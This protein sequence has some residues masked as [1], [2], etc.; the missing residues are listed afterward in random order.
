MTRPNSLPE[1]RPDHTPKPIARAKRKHHSRRS[2]LRVEQLEDRTTPSLLSTFELDGNA[3][4]TTSH[5]WDQVFA[6][7]GSPS[8][9]GST[10][11]ANGPLSGAL[12][13]G[14]TKDVTNSNTDDIFTGG[15][16]KDTNG[17]HNWLFT[18]SR[19][20]GKDDIEN[21]FAAAYTDPG[22]GHL[23]LYAGL[24]RFDNSGDSTA[25]F[26]FFGNQIGQ[27]PNVT[28]NGGHPFVGQHRN[29][30]I[31]L[32]SNFTQGGSVS[33]IAVYEWVGNDSTGGL[34]F[35]GG[36]STNTFAVVNSA[37]VSVPWSYTNKA[38]QSQPQAGEFLEE[39]VDLTALGLSGCFDSFTAE[40]RSSQ[41]PTATLSDFTL[42]R[43]PVCTIAAT[44]F[45][46]LSKFDTYTHQGDVVTY[47]L[48]VTNTG[49]VTLYLQNVTDTV[50]GNIAVNGVVQQP[51]AAGVN[52]FVTSITTSGVT[53]NGA[54]APGASATFFVSRPVQQTDPDPTTD[55]VTFVYNDDPGPTFGPD[56]DTASATN[57][58]NL[59]QPSVSLAETASAPAGVAGTP[60]TYTYTLTNT[61]SADSPNLVLD[62]SSPG[63]SFNS[64]LFGN[65]EA[66]AVH[67]LA[68][69][70][71][72]TTA[73]LAPGAS[74]SFTE[75]HVLSA[76]DPTPLTD[77]TGAVCTLAQNLGAFPNLI[78][79]NLTTVTVRIVNAEIGITGSGVNEVNNPHTFTVTVKEDLGDGNGFVPAANEP[80][81]VTLTSSPG[82]NP[83]VETP[84]SGTTDASGQFQVTFTSATAGEVI[85]S[86]TTTFTIQGVNL[87]RATSDS[88]VGDSGPATKFFEDA[89]ITISPSATN[90]ITEPHTFTVTL[91]DNAGDGSGYVPAANEPVAI[92]LTGPTGVN[93]IVETPLSGTTD[94]SGQFQATFTSATAGQFLGSAST[95]FTLNGVTLTRMTGD[96]K[97]ETGFVDGAPATNTF[98]AGSIRWEKVDENGNLLGGA[99]FLVTATDG[100]A[101]GL[102]PTSVSVLDNGPFDAD[103]TP[104]KFLLNSYQLF[105]SSALTGLAM[106]TYAVQE[107]IPPAG[108]TLDP[109][110]M[111]APLSLAA[112]NAD[113]SSTP[114]VDT[115]P[116]LTITKAVTPGFTPVIHPGDTASYTIT[117]TNTGAGTAQNIVATDPLP[118]TSQLTWTVSSFTGFTSASISGGVLTATDASLTGGASASITVSA[119]VPLNFFGNVGAANGDA[120]PSNLFEVDGNATVDTAGGHDWNQVHADNVANPKTNTAGALASSFVTDETTGDDIYTGGSTKDTQGISGWLFKTGKPQDKDEIEHAFAAQYKDPSTSDVILYVGADRFSNSGDSTLGAWFFV[121]P[122]AKSTGANV[123]G[124]GAP[125]TGTHA[126]G[127]FD[128]NHVFHGDILL[129]SNFTQGGSVSTIAVYGWLGSD[130][131]GSLVLLG[132]TASTVAVVNSGNPGVA[133]PYADK[134]GFSQPQAGEFIEEGVNLSGLGLNPCFSSFLLESRSSQSTTATLSDFI[135][136]SFQTCDVVLPNRASVSA[137]NFNS[138][139]PITSNTVTID[140]NDGMPQQAASVGSGPAT[141][142]L[143]RAQ[144]QP[145][146]ARAVAAWSAAGADPSALSNV[147]NYAIHI[148]PLPDGELG[149][150]VSGQIWIDPTAQGW[151]WSTGSTPAPGQMDL[152][153]VVT[154]EVGHVLGY[155]DHPGGN[156]IMTTALDAG[157]R[158]A[159]EAL[160]GSSAAVP[161]DSGTGGTVTAGAVAAPTLPRLATTDAP[162]VT[163]APGDLAPSSA[164]EA[165]SDGAGSATGIPLVLGPQGSATLFAPVAD[166]AAVPVDLSWR[167][168]VPGLWPPVPTGESDRR[169][170]SLPTDEAAALV[171]ELAPGVDP[172]DAD[173]GADVAVPI[174]VG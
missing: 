107:S 51:G 88:N 141:A 61:S 117:V 64:S 87:T 112:P 25:G 52:P 147:A 131:T 67:A 10:S 157:T 137:P 42:G 39:G 1:S 75:T 11:F 33:T 158:R 139:G 40:T 135:L 123:S 17:I 152:L 128:A 160:G 15:G 95:T 18:G 132:Q 171:G 127:F 20:Q 19:P 26:W 71:T 32:I 78:H 79:S 118:D 44:P 144:L 169:D 29:G 24:D 73:S 77:S 109:R 86:A 12:A 84:L 35:V 8:A 146:V 93:P 150:E 60:I 74:F 50:L 94:A 16:S 6:D 110:V 122:I 3:T 172:A 45:N 133:W 154:H 92:T 76:G 43:F 124:S 85:G 103:P 13:G 58:V 129:I 161:A 66:D 140:L 69:N 54:L 101:H 49:A 65:I 56:Q 143:T 165:I 134:A 47:P 113:L 37:A 121:N 9:L 148:A 23:V 167:V 80:V 115:L 119:A 105:G 104:G 159:P 7:A 14:F 82:V 163:E 72:A 28:T 136:G 162:V 27:N 106:G 151:G 164:T 111:S 108:Y 130:S 156:D 21:A 5:D 34:Q 142:S 22:T 46:G 57:T 174:D 170:T 100:T 62:T 97:G 91:L 155:G 63:D 99:T 166:P 120:V 126:T 70:S 168:L 145:V 2:H 96:G 36:N 125:F 81:T 89:Q 68:G 83:I 138:G 41:S 38:G 31:L 48:T 149:W 4:T 173:F 116:K 98:V 114:F 30:D 90:G 59:F 102:S 153:T 53:S 55:T